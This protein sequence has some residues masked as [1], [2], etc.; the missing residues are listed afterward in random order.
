MSTE[1]SLERLRFENR[2]ESVSGTASELAMLA[3]LGIESVMR[4]R[5][6]LR[7]PRRPFDEVLLNATEG[8]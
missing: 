8:V 1:P 6:L 2:L 7:E 3:K 5:P 4:L